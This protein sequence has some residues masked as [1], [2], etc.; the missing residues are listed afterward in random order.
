MQGGCSVPGDFV[1]DTAPEAAADYTCDASVVSC[2]GPKYNLPWR[3]Q[4]NY[5]NNIA[6]AMNYGY[7]SCLTLFTPQQVNRYCNPSYD[8]TTSGPFQG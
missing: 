4:L 3:G 7:D 2:G 6:T 5:R 8:D 1:E